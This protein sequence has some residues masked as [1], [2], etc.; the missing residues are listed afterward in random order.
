MLCCVH[1]VWRYIQ[2]ASFRQARWQDSAA[3]SA[4]SACTIH[5]ALARWPA[6]Q[7]T[8]LHVHFQSKRGRRAPFADRRGNTSQLGTQPLSANVNETPTYSVTTTIQSSGSAMARMMC[9][10]GRVAICST[11]FQGDRWRSHL[12]WLN[13]CIQLVLKAPLSGPCAWSVQQHKSAAALG[14]ASSSCCQTAWSGRLMIHVPQQAA[15]RDFEDNT[16]RGQAPDQLLKQ[17]GLCASRGCCPAGHRTD[18]VTTLL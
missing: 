10:N 11:Y 18:L 15:I 9:E 4:V 7:G 5:R 16:G 12:S 2:T 8:S 13:I 3:H 6:A 1:M 14:G 17:S